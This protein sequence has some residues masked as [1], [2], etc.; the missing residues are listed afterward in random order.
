MEQRKEKRA[1]LGSGWKFPVTVDGASGRIRMSSD[2]ENIEDSIR[3]ILSTRIGERV[4]APE[5]GCR[6]WEHSFENIEAAALR[7]M[8]TEAEQA[9]N[10]WEPRITEIKAKASGEKAQEGM[11]LLR[12]TYRLRSSDVLYE[13]DY[14]VDWN[15]IK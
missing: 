10:R 11:L 15:R 12:I 14:P 7:E 8:E 6:I 13:I 4:M 3:I 1:F 2:E 5:F 9:L